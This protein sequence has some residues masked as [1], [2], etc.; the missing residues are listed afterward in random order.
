MKRLLAIKDDP[1]A[2]GST[3]ETLKT[4]A[5]PAPDTFYPVTTAQ[6]NPELSQ[7]DRK[8]EVRGRRA[9][10]APISFAS[11]PSMTFSARA[12]PALIRKLL[13]NCLGG[14]ISSEG[15]APAA[16]SSTVETLQSGNLPVMIAW[17]LREGQLDRMTGAIVE[18][19]A[20]KFPID[21]EGTVDATLDALY[22]DVGH[23]ESA[24]D[25]NK[26]PAAAIPSGDY[27]PYTGDTFML[28]DATAFLGP[29]AGVEIPNL[30]GFNFTFNNGMIK[31][32]K[33]RFRPNKNIEVA[34]LEEVRHKLWYPNRHVLGAQQVTG[35]IE[36]SETDPDAE[37]KR[38]LAHA[39][40]L[41]VEIAAGPLGTTP[42]ADEM[43]RL[44]FY[45]T[46]KT[47][48]GADPLVREGDQTASYEFSAY[49]DEGTNKDVE[50]TFVGKT[51]LT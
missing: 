42:E 51:A 22:Q 23:A 41:V 20:F 35:T 18:E 45:K 27:T 34:T 47:G 25:P 19:L 32:L 49:L 29:E 26:K 5:I 30:A 15:A 24:E 14:A 31:D 8:D 44:V 28:R 39:Q 17:L 2:G 40:K 38:L 46:T 36:L 10:T 11:A 37:I 1:T 16:I 50:A 43:M 48:G 33:S 3:L 4:L 9:D 21:G 12:Y 13:R 7:V 6:T